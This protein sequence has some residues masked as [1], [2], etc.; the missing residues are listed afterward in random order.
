M[1]T[2]GKLFKISTFGE[3]HCKSVGVIIDGCPPGLPISQQQLQV[4][5]SRRRPGQNQLTTPR[6]EKDQVSIQSGVEFGFTLGTPICLTVENLDQKPH[7]YKETDYYPRPS[8]ADYSYLT[9]YNI[10]GKI[11]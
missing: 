10:K 11:K 8:H 5:L 2:F 7:D 6:D 1:S 9:K 4:Q 3:S